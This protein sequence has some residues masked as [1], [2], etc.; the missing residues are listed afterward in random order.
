M[1]SLTTM[2]IQD[3]VK[4]FDISGRLVLQNKTKKL[5]LLPSSFTF[6]LL[7]LAYFVTGSKV[8]SAPRQLDKEEKEKGEFV[9]QKFD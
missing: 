2:R 9:M 8:I 6:L 4:V 7:T 1:K 3:N 5:L